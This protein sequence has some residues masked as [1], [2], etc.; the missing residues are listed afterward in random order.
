MLL[1][2]SFQVFVSGSLR[3]ALKGSKLRRL[4]GKRRRVEVE[5]TTGDQF[6]RENF[7]TLLDDEE[8]EEEN[9]DNDNEE[10]EVEPTTGDQFQREK[11]QNFTRWSYNKFQH[12]HP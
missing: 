3:E 4:I 12:H 10:V 11:L 2:N 1:V 8:E 5:P 7:K 9:D 6:Q